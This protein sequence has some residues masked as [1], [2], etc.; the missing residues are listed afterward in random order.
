MRHILF[1]NFL[2]TLSSLATAQT[3]EGFE[4]SST[5]WKAGTPPT[6]SDSAALEALLSPLHA[7]EGK[8]TLELKFS[9]NQPKAI[10][11]V[12]KPFD[13]QAAA[14]LE[15]NVFNPDT[16]LSVA[17]ALSTGSS[18]EWFESDA[19]PLASGAQTVRFDLSSTTYK[20]AKT[21]WK[22]EGKL[23]NLGTTQRVALL[24]FPKVAGSVFVDNLRTGEGKTGVTPALS[25]PATLTAASPMPSSATSTPAEPTGKPSSTTTTVVPKAVPRA[26]TQ[27]S[28]QAVSSSFK[29]G[30]RAEW[31][32]ETDGVYANPFDP[33]QADPQATFTSPS[34]KTYR[35]PG[36][37]YQDFEETTLEPKGATHFRLR[38]VPL[39]AGSWTVS[40]SLGTTKS[41]PQ[42]F[43]VL[44]AKTAGFIRI[45]PKN[46]RYFAFDNGGPFL[47]I[48]PNIAWA[49][50]QGKSVLEDYRKWFDKLSAN[51]GNYARVWMAAWSFGLEWKDTGLGDYSG[52]LER[53]WLLD[54]VF[55]LAEARGIHLMLTLLN[56][57]QFSETVNSEWKDNPYNAANGGPLKTPA[58]FTTN[59]PARDLFKRKLRYT[60]A[61]YAASTSLFSWEWW[62]E[63]N[64]TPVSGDALERW[65]VEMTPVLRQS[66]PYHHL[67]SSSF[68]T[69]GTSNLWKNPDID[70]SQQHD[71]SQRDPAR[72]FSLALRDFIDTAPNKPVMLSELGYSSSGTD[73]LP[74]NRDAIQF[75]NGIWAPPFVGYAGPANYWWWDNFIEPQNLWTH[76]RGFA[77]FMAAEDLSQMTPF[78]PKLKNTLS[79]TALGMTR[80]GRTLV[81]VRSGGY[82][83]DSAK[84]AYSDALSSGKAGPSWKY[85]PPIL[86]RLELTLPHLAA[87]RYQIQFYA[88]QKNIWLEKRIVQ[89]KG[90]GLKVVM[91]S[92][93]KDLAFKIVLIK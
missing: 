88:P 62:N 76:Y 78:R 87:G 40:L 82:E 56:H 30:N 4:S 50:G 7:T 61:R 89:T 20:S 65:I 41:V 35:A 64:W 10:F 58:E 15:F 80:P 11:L 9:A 39:E 46:P 23:D 70:Y 27:V 38:F 8:G 48:G 42:K 12:E 49:T 16:A 63:V 79:A 54:K 74:I 75:H 69:G 71:Y 68:S 47:P 84:K 77:E 26:A 33:A 66:D 72:T 21:N 1:L 14:A 55:E 85:T 83:T 92:F 29:Q 51:G 34:G 17:L 19:L 5:L 31:K 57:G 32:L 25:A 28:L 3:L 93:D 2:L 37:W 53:A 59:S 73:D 44:E 52:R 13:L 43:E 6:Y 36:F 91:P 24:F 45:N 90:G 86:Y 22:L 60:V 81:W 18:W 67:I